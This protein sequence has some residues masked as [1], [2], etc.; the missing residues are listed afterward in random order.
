[1]TKTEL[2]AKIAEKTGLTKAQAGKA[3]DSLIEAIQE[4]L[5]AGGKVSI[6][7]FGTFEV[8]ERA[9]RKGRN[10]QTGAEIAIAAGRTPKFRAGK[11]LKDAM[12]KRS[13]GSREARQPSTTRLAGL[14]NARFQQR[15][16]IGGLLFK[17]SRGLLPKSCG[18]ERGEVRFAIRPPCL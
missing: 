9:T 18:V 8:S 3:H 17:N 6:S 5:K 11:A 15:P 14:K 10:P 13:H 2:I 7:G 12:G 1:M 16:P 4:E